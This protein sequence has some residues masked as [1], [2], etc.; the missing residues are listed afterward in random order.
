MICYYVQVSVPRPR[1]ISPAAVRDALGLA[2]LLY[3]AEREAGADGV[4]LAELEAAGR[5]LAE[6]AKLA[7]LDADTLGH[8]AALGRVQD[9]MGRLA[10]VGWPASL[11]ALLKAATRRF[12]VAKSGR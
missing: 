7:Q 4:R 5:L 3:E 6:G 2:R 8:R 11:E 10:A 9:G 12:E 1:L